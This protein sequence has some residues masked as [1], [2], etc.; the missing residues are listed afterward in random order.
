MD[1]LGNGRNELAGVG[2]SE[3]VE[4]VALVL[5]KQLVELDQTFVQFTADIILACWKAVV[6]L[7]ITVTLKKMKINSLVE[8]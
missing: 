2:F 1:L 6:V 3:R 8:A 5:R 7:A 4:L